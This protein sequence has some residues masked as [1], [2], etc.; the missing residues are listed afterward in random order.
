MS[1]GVLRFDEFVRLALYGEDGLLQR[2]R[3][4]RPPRWALPDVAGGRAA[5]R[6]GPG[7]GD[8]RLVAATRCAGPTSPS[9][10]SAP[11]RARWP[12]RS[13]PPSRPARRATSPSR[14][15]RRSAPTI[16]TGSSRCAELPGRAVRGVVIANELLDNLPFRLAVFDGG[17]REAFVAADGEALREVLAAPLD[18]VP[19]W[20]PSTAPHGARAPIQD[21]AA[22][23]VAGRPAR[24]RGAAGSSSSTTPSPARPS[25]RSVPWREWLRTFRGHERGGHYLADP[26]TQDITVEVCL[27]QLPDARRGAHARPSSSPCTASTSSVEEGRAEWRRPDLGADRCAR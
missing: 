27:D 10:R 1:R 26:G 8:R 25:W 4:G 20:L 5:V 18:P 12:G 2:R 3:A 24:D 11:V 15:P 9:S 6:R 23:W 16:P 13:S 19:A 17:W 22:G 14:S 21:D 7:P